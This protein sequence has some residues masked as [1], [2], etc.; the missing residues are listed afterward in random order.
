[1]RFSL[2]SF[3]LSLL[4]S[5]TFA[6][7]YGDESY[8]DLDGKFWSFYSGGVAVIDPETC[9][10]ENVI[11]TDNSGLSLPAGWSDGIYMQYFPQEGDGHSHN[12]RP[13]IENDLK[14]YVL[15]NSRINRDNDTGDTVSDV[16]IFNTETKEVES[17]VEVGPRVVHSYG[18]HNRY[19]I[20]I[21][22]YTT[23]NMFSYLVT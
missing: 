1:M 9:S 4:I 23:L 7:L 17:V 12:I 14:G 22:P 5:P 15:I 11:T 10:I 2:A 13:H 6:V 20:Q 8:G 19:V 16:Y 18:I 3:S 21:F